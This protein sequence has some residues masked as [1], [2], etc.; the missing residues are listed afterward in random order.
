[1]S[2]S[3]L[4]GFTEPAPQT[5]KRVDEA[6]DGARAFIAAFDPELIV[7]FAPAPSNGFFSALM[8]R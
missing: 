6:L 7:A 5:R 3:P 8:P 4:M 1:M 2:H